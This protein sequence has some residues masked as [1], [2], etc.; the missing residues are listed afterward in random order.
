AVIR[1]NGRTAGAVRHAHERRLKKPPEDE[2]WAYLEE[3]S[4]VSE[5]VDTLDVDD[6]NGVFD[7]LV[8]QYRRLERLRGSARRPVVHVREAEPDNRWAALVRV[9]GDW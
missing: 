1:H 9:I 3:E 7:G 2:I 8:D 6:A 4:W 5:V